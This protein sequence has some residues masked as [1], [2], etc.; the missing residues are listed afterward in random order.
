MIISFRTL[1]FI[2]R[3]ATGPELERSRLHHTCNYCLHVVPPE[4]LIDHAMEHATAV[5]DNGIP[6]HPADDSFSEF[7][8]PSAPIITR[9]GDLTSKDR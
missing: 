1:A 4:E 2:P 3:P 6:S 5:G 8:T 7:V 9:G